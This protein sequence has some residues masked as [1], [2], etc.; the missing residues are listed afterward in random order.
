MPWAPAWQR[1]LPFTSPWQVGH[2]CRGVSRP[3][4]LRAGRSQAQQLRAP[5]LTPGGP[6]AS[7]GPWDQG[8][9][10]GAE[11]R[12]PGRRAPVP[13]D[14]GFVPSCVRGPRLPL[15]ATSQRA[16]TG[17]AGGHLSPKK[18]V[19][20][21]SARR[22]TFLTSDLLPLRSKQT[23]FW[24]PSIGRAPVGNWP[25]LCLRMQTPGCLPPHRSCQTWGL[26]GCGGGRGVVQAS[27]A[28]EAG[29]APLLGQIQGAGSSEPPSA[30][31]LPP[32]TEDASGTLF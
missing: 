30:L 23:D 16:L 17:P 18:P 25:S 26:G 7:P 32:S 12:G 3:K 8:W 4:S 29:P 19:P 2:W 13:P 5:F 1:A 22:C 24:A 20:S 31:R 28:G 9:E 15:G 6:E 21:R 14:L 10:R 11:P 27:R